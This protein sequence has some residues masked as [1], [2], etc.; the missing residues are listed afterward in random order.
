MEITLVYIEGNVCK[1]TKNHELHMQKPQPGN[2][3]L[4]VVLQNIPEYFSYF[5]SAL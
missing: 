4:E 5:L 1:D 2:Y 3:H